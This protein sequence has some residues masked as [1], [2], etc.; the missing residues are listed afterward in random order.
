MIVSIIWLD[1][2]KRRTDRVMSDPLQ[3]MAWEGLSMA[4]RTPL[5]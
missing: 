1:F 2:K 4:I 3:P 5:C